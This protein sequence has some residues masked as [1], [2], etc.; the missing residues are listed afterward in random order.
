MKITKFNCPTCGAAKVNPY[1]GPYVCCDYCGGLTD[2]DAVIWCKTNN[3]PKRLNNFEE[4]HHRI[5]AKTRKAIQEN[6]REL[7]F[8]SQQEYF[9]NYYNIY[10]EF[11]PPTIAKGESFKSFLKALAE[12]ATDLQFEPGLKS[13]KKRSF[14]DSKRK[15][16]TREDAHYDYTVFFM[17]MMEDHSNYLKAEITA[18]TSHSKYEF[19]NNIYPEGFEYKTKMAIFAQPYFV[20]MNDAQIKHYL[21]KFNFEYEFVDIVATQGNK[22]NCIACE[23][24]ITLAPGAFRCICENC[25]EMNVILRNINCGNCGIENILPER[26]SNIIN[27]AG[28]NTEIRVAS[29]AQ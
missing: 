28:C 16:E 29:I 4:L 17:K 6:N 20:D 19:L 18:R 7:Y 2:I 5:V 24:S 21:K 12:W 27:C 8:R 22:I 3:I 9:N 11:I 26:W 10:P 23:S 25:F 1:N 15:F 14:E 13:K